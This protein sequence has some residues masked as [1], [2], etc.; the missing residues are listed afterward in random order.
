[1]RIGWLSHDNSFNELINNL[2]L[3]NHR[4]FY[5]IKNKTS[6][7]Y[8][9]NLFNVESIHELMNLDLDVLFTYFNDSN[10]A[11]SMFFHGILKRCEELN[12]KI[13]IIDLSSISVNLVEKIL[14]QNTYIEY[15]SAPIITHSS[16]SWQSSYMMPI[17]GK[18]FIFDKVNNL[19][20]DLE[21]EYFYCGGLASAQILNSANAMLNSFVTLGIFEA[22][23]YAISNDLN[24][25][26]LYEAVNLGAGS[27]DALSNFFQKIVSNDFDDLNKNLVNASHLISNVLFDNKNSSDEFLLSK[28]I[29]GIL[30]KENNN[31]KDL[32]SQRFANFY[33]LNSLKENPF[34]Q[35]NNEFNAKYVIDNNYN[36]FDDFKNTS[37]IESKPISNISNEVNV[38]ESITNTSIDNN[39]QESNLKAKA[40]IDEIISEPQ[41]ESIFDFVGNKSDA[42]K[43][44]VIKDSI[45]LKESFKNNDVQPIEVEYQSPNSLHE[46]TIKEELKNFFEDKV[47]EEKGSLGI[48]ENDFVE[49]IITPSKKPSDIIEASFQSSNTNKNLIENLISNQLKKNEV[50]INSFEDSYI[51]NE[52]DDFFDMNLQTFNDNESKVI[53]FDLDGTLLN[54]NKEVNKETIKAIQE[55]YQRGHEVVIATGRSYQ[56]TIDVVN[57]IGVI[58]YV[59]M[60]N[61][62]LIYDKENNLIIRNTNPLPKDLIKYFFDIVFAKKIPF[63]LYSDLDVF[64]YHFSSNEDFF[65]I[66]VND[67]TIDISNMSVNE[68]LQYFKD[69]NIDIFNL[70]AYSEELTESDWVEM[71][72]YYKEDLKECNLTSALKHSIDIYGGSISKY[73]GYL[74]LKELLQY[75]DNN[76]YFFGD[77]NNDFDLMCYVENGIAMGNANPRLK[78]VAKYVI[79]DNNSN[80]I[81]DFIRMNILNI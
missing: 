15:L 20:A 73:V 62:G 44:V 23:N 76:V 71:F 67:R 32:Y 12:M 77:S 58:R 39:T 35:E 49:N 61:G 72:K 70:C 46:V 10:E 24:L 55:A 81:A 4:I 40:I 25:K 69:N 38:D 36:L 79:G 78:S 41:S 27:S 22:I 9:N 42:N 57:E 11:Y 18:K 53:I 26:T 52:M 50:N 7:N 1:M 21:I 19:L 54:E 34:E 17:S 14:L 2:T 45:E 65:S 5:Y 33:N 63:L 68:L 47:D 66:Y 31:L 56:Q 80:A 29:Y 3:S 16:N 51:K 37:N 75:S 74:K 13:L 6:F 48:K 64:V 28:V 43:Q 8:N 30:K 60:N 59:I